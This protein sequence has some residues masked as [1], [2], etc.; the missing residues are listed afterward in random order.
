MSSFPSGEKPGAL[1]VGGEE[2][3]DRFE[4][5]VGMTGVVIGDL[6]LAVG[7]ELFGLCFGEE[8]SRPTKKEHRTPLIY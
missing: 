4:V 6:R 3:D 1:R 5:Y 7:F 2:L 8:C